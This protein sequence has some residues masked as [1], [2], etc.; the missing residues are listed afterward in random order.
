MEAD[1]GMVA[2]AIGSACAWAGGAGLAQD[3]GTGISVDTVAEVTGAATASPPALLSAFAATGGSAALCAASIAARKANPA[4]SSASDQPPNPAV[5]A[6][7][8]IRYL[9]W[10]ASLRRACAMAAPSLACRA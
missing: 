5:R 2:S 3:V 4:R 1:A 9:S 8:P 10:S 7:P 6:K